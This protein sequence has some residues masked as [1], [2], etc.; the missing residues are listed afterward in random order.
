MGRRR[1]GRPPQAGSLWLR[2]AHEAQ[3]AARGFSGRGVHLRHPEPARQSPAGRSRST[4]STSAAGRPPT[5]SPPSAAGGRSISAASVYGGLKDRHA[6]TVPVPHHPQRAR[7]GPDHERIQGHL[8]RPAGEPY[9]SEHIAANRSRSPCGACRRPTPRAQ[10]H[11]RR[12]RT[13]GLPNYFDDQRFGSVGDAPAFVAREMVARPVRGGAEARAGRPVRARPG[14][15]Q[16]REG[17][18]SAP[19]G[20]TGPRSRRTAQR[21]RPEPRR[22][23]RPPP[24]RLQGRLARLR[25][26]L[27]GLYLSAWQSHLWNRMLAAWLADRVPADQLIPHS[28]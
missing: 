7:E 11:C 13:S 15:G 3:A 14:R 23:P 12:S 16:A 5:P 19:A 27:Q 21:A 9:T 20:A 1:G 28:T 25:P 8:P 6:V 24:D 17:D 22:L 26:E 4:G 18:R 2:W 10:R